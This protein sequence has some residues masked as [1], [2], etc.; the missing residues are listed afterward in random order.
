MRLAILMMLLL[1]D[2]SVRLV[3]GTKSWKGVSVT[4]Y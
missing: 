4:P 3:T 2:Q 1:T